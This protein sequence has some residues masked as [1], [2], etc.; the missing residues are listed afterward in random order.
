MN[1]FG[2]DANL[3]GQGSSE[4]N[5]F[6]EELLKTGEIQRVEL[7]NGEVVE[8]PIIINKDDFKNRKCVVKIH[9]QLDCNGV[10]SNAI[11]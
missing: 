2:I 4:W 10:S 7:E 8:K 9:Y 3:Y 11:L 5:K 1:T 6:T